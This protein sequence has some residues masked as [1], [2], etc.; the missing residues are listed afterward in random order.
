[1]HSRAVT[2][3]DTVIDTFNYFEEKTAQLTRNHNVNP[4]KGQ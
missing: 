2:N 3:L 1:M 4:S